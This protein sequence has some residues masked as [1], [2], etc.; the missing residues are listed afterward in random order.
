[1]KGWLRLLGLVAFV[2]LGIVIFRAIRQ[3]REDSAF[4]VP[5]ATSLPGEGSRR[6]ISP[7]L[8]SIL[9]DPGD[10]GP[11]ELITDSSGKEWLVNRRN[12]F[13]YPVEDGIPIMLLEEG[14]KNKDESLIQK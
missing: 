14:E 9:A 10:K 11:V 8:L 6:V 12:G 5:Q 3:Y 1:M 2:G 13:R 4:D 7:E